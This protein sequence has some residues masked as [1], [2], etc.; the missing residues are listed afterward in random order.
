MRWSSR[1]LVCRGCPEP[2]LSVN[3]T[4]W[5]HWSQHLLTVKSLRYHTL[6]D[7]TKNAPSE[8]DNGSKLK[9]RDKVDAQ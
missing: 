3:D 7:K 8:T 1:R 9:K 2:G 6:G 5:I 4:S